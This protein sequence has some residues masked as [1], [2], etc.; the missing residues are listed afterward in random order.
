[1][2]SFLSDRALNKLKILQTLRETVFD[3]VEGS[4]L[5]LRNLLPSVLEK[6]L[7]SEPK[8]YSGIYSQGNLNFTSYPSRSLNQVS[9][10]RDSLSDFSKNTSGGSDF[11]T[12]PLHDSTSF[13]TPPE[14]F[15]SSSNN[16]NDSNKSA[17]KSSENNTTSNY[18][19]CE[20]GSS[21]QE[22]HKIP[23]DQKLSLKSKENVVQSV[24]TPENST[25]CEFSSNKSDTNAISGSSSSLSGATVSDLSTDINDESKQE[26]CNAAFSADDSPTRCSSS[27]KTVQNEMQGNSNT[28]FDQRDVNINTSD[29]TQITSD[30]E[31]TH[32]TPISADE[33]VETA[34]ADTSAKSNVISSIDT[35]ST[36]QSSNCVNS[37]ENKTVSSHGNNNVVEESARDVQID[38]LRNQIFRLERELILLQLDQSDAIDL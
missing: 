6:H 14:D 29:N 5:P 9:I 22:S 38:N 19:S 15:M 16:G 18:V 21:F 37:N 36:A 32:S 30:G 2:R 34:P 8:L 33:N 3:D 7:R 24:N 13:S 10:L 35:D 4:P 11:I 27:L 20:D 31:P 23:S 25:F 17:L 28:Q 1:M 26:T 12:A